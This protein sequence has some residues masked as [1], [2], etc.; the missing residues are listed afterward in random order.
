MKVLRIFDV[1]PFVHAGAVNKYAMLLP[2]LV[3][4]GESFEERRIYAGGASLI[5]NVLYYEYGKCSM[6]SA[7]IEWPS[8]KQW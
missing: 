4:N 2:E 5:W 7:V 1:S 8:V 3:D 6:Y